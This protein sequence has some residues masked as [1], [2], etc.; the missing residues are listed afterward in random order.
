MFLKSSFYTHR[1]EANRRQN[2]TLPTLGRQTH[3]VDKQF[4]TPPNS[5]R[6]SICA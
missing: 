2:G 1:R 3:L 6:D 5:F 4:V